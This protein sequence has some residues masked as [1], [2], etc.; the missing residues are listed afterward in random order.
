MNN[1]EQLIQATYTRLM[2]QIPVICETQ[3]ILRISDSISFVNGI[4]LNIA[5]IGDPLSINKQIYYILKIGLIPKCKIS[6]TLTPIL[7]SSDDILNIFEDAH[8]DQIDT[9]ID[10]GTIYYNA[11]DSDHGL[12]SSRP[13]IGA[14][15]ERFGR[16]ISIISRIEDNTIP[17]TQMLVSRLDIRRT[18]ESCIKGG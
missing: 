13:D 18:I 9:Y 6:W 3:H 2:E 15:H 17:N 4:I 10:G 16:T 14:I 5:N 12:W 1:E 7:I 8:I 11:Y